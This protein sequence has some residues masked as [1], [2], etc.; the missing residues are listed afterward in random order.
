MSRT[1]VP[2]FHKNLQILKNCQQSK[3]SV[4]AISAESIATLSLLERKLKI[5]GL[6][7]LVFETY[8]CITVH[9]T[10]FVFQTMVAGSKDRSNSPMT[11]E[12]FCVF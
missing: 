9:I 6:N 1:M 4:R 11:S 10:T 7:V 5:D 12:A 8:S 3:L 2:H